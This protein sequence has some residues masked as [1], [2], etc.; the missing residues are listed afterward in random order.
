MLRHF[1]INHMDINSIVNSARKIWLSTH[2]SADGDGIGSELAFY[3]A[4]KKINK[5]VYLIHNDPIPPRYNF[6]VQDNLILNTQQVTESEYNENDVAFIFDTNDP[7]ICQPLYDQLVA[8]NITVIFVDHHIKLSQPSEKLIHFIDEKASCSGELTHELIQQLG[9]KLNL[10][11]ATCLYTSL[12]FDTQ[13]FKNMRDPL[14]ILK[15][16]QKLIEA[17]AEHSTI[18]SH[19]FENWTVNK[20]NYL[21]KLIERVSYKNENTAIIRMSLADLAEYQL[22]SDEVSDIIDLFMGVKN[23]QVSILVREES[24]Q[25]FKLSFRSRKNEILSWAQEFGGGGHLYSA[26][27]WVRDT[28]YNI[29]AKLDLL[30]NKIS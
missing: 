27:A 7:H 5:D 28:E 18:Q 29:L 19:L 1:N 11:M 14:K 17:G 8:A 9:I 26:G 25:Y 22:S 13:N 12:L 16:A 20:F 10:Q 21:A 23:L 30:I 15:L 2:L 6:L 24:S 3:H 4:L